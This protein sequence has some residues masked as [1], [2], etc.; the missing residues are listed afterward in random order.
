MLACVGNLTRS[1]NRRDGMESKGQSVSQSEV[2]WMNEENAW[3]PSL[4]PA[5][6]GRG[7]ARVLVGS[8]PP[9]HPWAVGPAPG[10]SEATRTASS[11]A[12]WAGFPNRQWTSFWDDCLTVAGAGDRV[13]VFL[14][15]VSL[16]SATIYAYG[17]RSSS[18]EKFMGTAFLRSVGLPTMVAFS[19]F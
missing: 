7:G 13:V 12:H 5:E 11:R 1:G 14:V 3:T 16:E 10:A 2:P 8:P 4:A 18:R 9:S 6:P 17:D 15:L 19:S